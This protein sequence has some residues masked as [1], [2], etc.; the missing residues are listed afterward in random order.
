MS[1][2]SRKGPKPKE[3]PRAAEILEVDDSYQ[4]R[5]LAEQAFYIRTHIQV[6]A[7]EV[8]KFETMAARSDAPQQVKDWLKR[9]HGNTSRYFKPAVNNLD[10]VRFILDKEHSGRPI[11]E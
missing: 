8:D 6:L 10:Q 9:V 7:E 2:K 3:E 5:E 11:K 1:S 4:N